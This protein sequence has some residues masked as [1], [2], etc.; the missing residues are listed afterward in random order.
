M[1]APSYG[2]PEP[3]IVYVHSVDSDD[4]QLLHLPCSVEFEIVVSVLIAPSAAIQRSRT[5]GHG[6]AIWLPFFTTRTGVDA[7]SSHLSGLSPQVIVCT[8]TYN[9]CLFLFYCSLL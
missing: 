8:S 5:R 7:A 6:S 2:G 1:A 4:L 3:Q 9:V